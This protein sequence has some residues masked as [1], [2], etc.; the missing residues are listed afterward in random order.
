MVIPYFSKL[1]SIVFSHS[2]YII[3][4]AIIFSLFLTNAVHESYP[5][6]F[7]NIL[8]GWYMLHGKFLYSGFFTHHNPV[9][10]ILSAGIELLSGQSF[11]RFRL[12]YAVGL[13]AYIVWTYF[14]L[15]KRFTF[16]NTNFYL[17]FILLFGVGATYFWGHMLLA[18]NL[19]ALFILPAFSLLFLRM[20]YKEKLQLS[21][22]VY[23]SVF[24]SLTFLTAATYIY[25]ICVIYLFSFIFYIRGN[26][27][28]LLS[29]TVLKVLTIFALPYVIFLVYLLLT[30]GLKDYYYQNIV[31]NPRFYI[32][33]YP[34][35][36][37]APVNPI[38]YAIIIANDF[39]NNFSSLLL[40]V[41]DFNFTFP[42]NMTLAVAN[43]A[44]AI[45]LLIQRRFSLALFAILVIIYT[46]VRTN[47]LTSKETDYQLSVYIL[48][49]FF[50]LSFLLKQ[51][52]EDLEQHITSYPKKIIFAFLLLI[53]GIYTFFCFSLLFR[54][55]SEKTFKK[56]M[57]IQ[58]LIYDR[59]QIAPLIHRLTDVDDIVWIG[60]F[61]FEE[62]FYSNRK[63][64][65]KYIILL[66]EFAKFPEIKDEFMTD[67][68][69]QKPKV[70]Y[71]DKT[72]SIRGYRPENF[73]PFFLEYLDK[74]Y[75]RLL[76]YKERDKRYVSVNEP[77]EHLDLESKLYIRKDQK[78]IMIQKLL[79]QNLIKKESA[80]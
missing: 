55:Y 48:L 73:A 28:S 69:K 12:I 54:K 9:A 20:F 65:S 4:F 23:I 67:F 25:L 39:Y 15:S 78:D 64:P 62:L 45:Y 77:T 49:S 3:F 68:E 50:I 1:K 41:K 2:A 8:G 75:I 11:V 56:Y 57:G 52:Y 44:L 35:P 36:E 79:D 70:V 32:Y 33:N 22:I 46:N 66:P 7:D 17:F 34:R 26:K 5:D 37:G 40:G 29:F 59:P 24:S 71:F 10:Y 74:N 21:D 42:F 53:L 18:D 72:Y 27:L 47:V 31:F 60:P 13:F 61:E 51:L 30:G 38:R 6:E 19:A 80:E 14:F 63:T 58:A 16:K 43:T 76:D